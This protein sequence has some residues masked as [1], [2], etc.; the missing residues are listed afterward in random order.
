MAGW[1]LS[2]FPER[3]IKKVI[4]NCEKLWMKLIL[5]IKCLG[6]IQLFYSFS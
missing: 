1:F 4:P 6:L 2:H 5:Q 3:G